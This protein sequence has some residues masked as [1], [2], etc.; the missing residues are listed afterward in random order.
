MVKS[1]GL[2][3]PPTTFVLT[4]KNVFEPIGAVELFEELSSPLPPFEGVKLFAA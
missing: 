2:L 4:V 1:E 3:V